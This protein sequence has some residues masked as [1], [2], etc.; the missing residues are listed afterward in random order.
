MSHTKRTWTVENTWTCNTCSSPN[1]GRFTSCQACGSAKDKA[2]AAS[3]VVDPSAIVT[4]T[5]LLQQAA[6][7]AHWQCER[8]DG[9][10]RDTAGN[11]VNCGGGRVESVPTP[12]FVFPSPNDLLSS[13][14]REF[15]QA[16]E[17]QQRDVERI[18][19]LSAIR[20]PAPNDYIKRN[21]EVPSQSTW[22]PWAAG[23]AIVAVILSLIFILMPREKT[24]TVQETR[25]FQTTRYEEKTT[26][27][28]SGWGSPL[29]GEVIPGSMQCVRKQRGWEKCNKHSCGTESERYVCGS[30]E[31]GC[32]NVCRNN[33]NGFS[34]CSEKCSTRS[35]YCTR[36]VTKYCWDQCPVHDNWCEYDVWKW[37]GRGER[38]ANGVGPDGLHYPDLGPTD[39]THRSVY[40][41][42][43]I[44]DFICDG[45]VGS[46]A[47]ENAAA[48]QLFRAGQKWKGTK[49]LIGSFQPKELVK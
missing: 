15:R 7:G 43:Y 45:E 35:K 11:C 28:D 25:W 16:L 23:I 29:F 24:A 1:K 18:N 9:L 38:T 10:Q 19:D 26:V 20:Q 6:E 31:Y 49:S 17:D 34:T 5:P 48:F 12:R 41:G 32:H 4:S 46:H 33:G 3:E 39:T 36:Q 27:H 14:E 13:E 47:P 37:V 42:S 8:C 40:S 22:I 21:Y 44:V 2:E 30:E